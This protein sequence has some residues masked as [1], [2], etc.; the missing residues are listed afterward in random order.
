M[1][2]VSF[3]L[4]KREFLQFDCQARQLFGLPHGIIFEHLRRSINAALQTKNFDC[5][6]DGINNDVNL[7]SSGSVVV[8]LIDAVSPG[9]AL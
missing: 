9:S 8:Q 4:S 5:F 1:V 7:R 6:P 2:V 3:G